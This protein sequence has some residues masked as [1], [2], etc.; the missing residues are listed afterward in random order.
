MTNYNHALDVNYNIPINKI[1][2]FNWVTASAKYNAGYIWT[3]A[4]LSA[5][6]LGNTIENTNTKQLNGSFN[7]INLYNKVGY[8]KKL[9][10]QKAPN[11]NSNKN[12]APDK[13]TNKNKSK[14]SNKKNLQNKSDSTQTD[15]SKID[16][17]KAITDNLLKFLMGVKNVSFSYSQGNGTFIPGYML[18]PE[19][20]G[21]DPTGK[22]PG[23]GFIFGDQTDIRP[24]FGNN[25]SFLSTDSSMNYPYATK[26]TENFTAR[27]TIEPINKLMIELSATRTFSDNHSEYYKWNNDSLRY[28]KYNPTETGAY[29]VSIFS[30]KTAFTIDNKTTNS[31]ATF[32]KFKENLYTIAWRLANKN[33][34]WINY[35][36]TS[37]SDSITR[38]FSNKNFPIGY[39]PTNQDVMLPA[40][41]A[42]YTGKERR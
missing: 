30:F 36:N 35:V 10:Q 28:M 4:P 20:I 5:L 22:Y 16:L 2:W 7:L 15:S 13:N 24:R 32:E 1:P 26:F 33:K 18:T 29:S 6:S 21:L 3:G 27:A 34:N 40:F 25:T 39:G 19:F 8:L 23:P 9:N 31:N 38:K 37:Y 42:A 14:N 41:L 11:T 17:A 12:K